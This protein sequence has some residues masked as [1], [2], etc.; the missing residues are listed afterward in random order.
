VARNV[1][2]SARVKSATNQSAAT[3]SP[4]PVARDVG[5]LRQRDVVTGDQDAVPADD[6]VRLDHIGVRGNR[7]PIGLDRVLGVVAVGATVGEDERRLAVER[8]QG[9]V[10]VTAAAA[11]SQDGGAE[12]D[13]G[14]QLKHRHG[15]RAHGGS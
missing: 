10:V 15:T 7:E 9:R 5:R 3:G 14:G 8:C 6:D 2:S 4:S 11:G 1:L 13:G 12:R